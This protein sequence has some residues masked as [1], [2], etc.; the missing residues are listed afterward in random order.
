METLLKNASQARPSR[1]IFVQT[2]DLDQMQHVQLGNVS[3][4][5]KKGDTEDIKTGCQ[6]STCSNNFDC[7]Y[8]EICQSVKGQNRCV[9]AC[10]NVQCGPNSHCVTDNHHNTCICLDGFSGKPSDFNT[11]CERDV[12][13]RAQK[14]CPPGF[15]CSINISDKR[16]CGSLQNNVLW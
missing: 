15:L 16:S 10:D 14:D 9:D 2:K 12:T 11:G 7:G 5:L 3:V 4:F 8:N 13:C 1:L 6:S